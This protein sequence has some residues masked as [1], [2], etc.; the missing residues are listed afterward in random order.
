MIVAIAVT[1]AAVIAVLTLAL[2]I[3]DAARNGY[4]IT[5]GLTFKLAKQYPPKDRA[6]AADKPATL[7]GVR[8]TG[9]AA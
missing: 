3:R 6:A 1:G 8:D 2:V 7:T 9:S 5:G 4:Q